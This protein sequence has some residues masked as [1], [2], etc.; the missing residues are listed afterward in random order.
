MKANA[1]KP[2]CTAGNGDYTPDQ[3]NPSS[4]GTAFLA[5]AVIELVL[6]FGCYF[7]G[8]QSSD[9]DAAAEKRQNEEYIKNNYT[10]SAGKWIGYD[11]EQ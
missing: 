11:F 10:S 3:V 8:K 1:E 7:C 9:S 4:K 2:T 6:V 5:M